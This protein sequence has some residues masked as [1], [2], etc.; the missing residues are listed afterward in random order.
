[1]DVAAGSISPQKLYGVPVDAAFDAALSK[2][3]DTNTD[4]GSS[5]ENQRG[6]DDRHFKELQPEDE[7]KVDEEQDEPDVMEA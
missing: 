5:P 6:G 4:Q 2:A 3:L 7:G 1:V